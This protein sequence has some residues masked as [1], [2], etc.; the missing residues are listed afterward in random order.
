MTKEQAH[1]ADIIARAND[2]RVRFNLTQAAK[3]AGRSR[4]G[5]PAWLHERGVMVEKSGKDKYINVNDL[6][7]AMTK[8]RVSPI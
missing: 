7:A 6:A 8:N 4:T 3:I 5:F 1:L 2:G